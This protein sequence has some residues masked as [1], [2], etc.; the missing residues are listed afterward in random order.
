MLKL[1]RRVASTPSVPIQV[2]TN[3]NSKQFNIPTDGYYNL[4]TGRIITKAQP[5]HDIYL[6]KS[7][8]VAGTVEQ[9]QRFATINNI[10]VAL[11]EPLPIIEHLKLPKRVPRHTDIINLTSNKVDNITAFS[12]DGLVVPALVTK[13]YDGDTIHVKHFVPIKY[14]GGLYGNFFTRK[15]AGVFVDTTIRMFGLDAV[16]LNTTYGPKARDILDNYLKDQKHP[17]YIW[18]SFSKR[19]KYGRTLA[20]IWLR[21][22]TDSSTS[23]NELLLKTPPENG[24][25]L[26]KPY[27]GGKR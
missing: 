3:L 23:V 6:A 25:L 1:F 9:L 21:E 11:V 8:H 17:Y 22:A 15:N 14:L 26:F 2:A 5:E 7:L 4:N 12:L 16:E 27:Y 18:V 13:V 10:N 19:D 24:V 20:V